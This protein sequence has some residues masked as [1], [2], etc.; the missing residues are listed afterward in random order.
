MSSSTDRPILN[1]RYEIQS[2]LGRGGMADVFL[3]HDRLLDRAVAVKVLFPEYAND[4]NFVERFRREAQAAAN[5]S[6]PNIVA[7][8]DW[9]QAGTT[10]FIV[11]EYVAGRTLGEIV[12]TDGPLMAQRAAD[13]ADEVA[14]ALGFAHRNGVVHRDVKPGNILVA[15]NG[16]VKVADF[17][18]ARA[19]NSAT[20]QGLTQ[21]G[22]VMGTA[23][24]FSPEQA[25]GANPDPRSDLYSLGIVMHEMVAGQP[26]FIGDNPVAIAYRQVH[27]QPPALSQLRPDVPRGYEAIVSKL[28][29]KKPELR[30][31]TADELRAD[32][33]RFRDGQT[34]L[35]MAPVVAVGTTT[36]PTPAVRPAAVIAAAPPTRAMPAGPV[37]PPIVYNIDDE[38]PNRTG[39]WV[40]A[41]LLALLLLGLAGWFLW[42]AVTDAGSTSDRVL[43]KDVRNQTLDVA[44]R[45]LEADGLKPVEKPLFKDGIAIGTVYDQDPLPGAEIAT[46]SEVILTFNP[47]KGTV[48]LP[49]LVGMDRVQA[50]AALSL[51]GLSA[52][53]EERTDPTAA[54]GIVIAQDPPAGDI[55][56]GS[57]VKLTV[58]LGKGEVEVPNV[59][60]QDQV[61]AS[62]TL[63]SKGFQVNSVQE[64]SDSVPG[65]KVIRTDPA[66]GAT[67]EGGST[68]TMVVSSGPKP[69]AVPNVEGLTESAA[70]DAL[71]TAGFLQSVKYVD[72]QIPAEQAGRVIS[73]SPV[74]G[75]PLAKGSTVT[76]TVSRAAPPP[77][78][79][80]PPTT[81]T[82]APPP[83]TTAATTTS[84]T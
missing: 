76:I 13:I 40:L 30:Y 5:L 41:A 39:W 42:R 35:A 62:A 73:Q 19:L 61:T 83:T 34:V 69:V 44:K 11:M 60:G 51:L 47:G 65:G 27:D 49:N 15:T 24:Y 33:R 78:T 29:A 81:T 25:Q 23:T 46:G 37:P 22:A 3:G 58:S 38:G 84:S 12:R 52:N 79:T 6:H 18:I 59:I 77:T 75:T 82:T 21:A 14:G 63:A 67:A 57:T 16:T 9:G 56:A 71:Q 2:R 32:L 50:E 17:G 64:P 26:P 7:V 66:A 31:Q 10:Y 45:T 74:A 28:L 20:E 68:V 43:V 53:V 72:L 70:R 54:A 80:A 8:Y 36:A 48:K 1:D 55:P 4:P